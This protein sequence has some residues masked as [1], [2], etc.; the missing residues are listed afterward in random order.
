M[1]LGEKV[2]G[3]KKDGREIP[4]RPLM[5]NSS[6]FIYLLGICSNHPLGKQQSGMR[7]QY[8]R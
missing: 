2:Y 6:E 5:F 4:S 8:R 7:L 1:D 3:I